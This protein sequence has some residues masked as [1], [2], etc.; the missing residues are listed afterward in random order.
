MTK[1]MGQLYRVPLDEQGRALSIA[2]AF[3]FSGNPYDDT[4]I[5]FINEVDKEAG[6]MEICLFHPGVMPDNLV[7]VLREQMS[8]DET[9]ALLRKHCDANEAV[10]AAWI[11]AVN[12][13]TYDEEESVH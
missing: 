7:K 2:G 10:K 12:G 13:P 3:V 5:G 11:E 6:E 9:S 8:F 1:Q 4:V